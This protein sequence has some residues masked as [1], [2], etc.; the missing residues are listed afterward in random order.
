MGY[1]VY[2][3]IKQLIEL[4]KLT[5]LCPEQAGLSNKFFNYQKKK[6]KMNFFKLFEFE[7]SFIS[8]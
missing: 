8:N 3:L 7:S 6:Y 5:H 2:Q 1:I 4:G